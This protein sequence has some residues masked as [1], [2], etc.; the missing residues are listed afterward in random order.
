MVY[1]VAAT[2][3]G[4]LF[5]LES[6]Y[7]DV[8]KKAPADI[9]WVFLTSLDVLPERDNVTVLVRKEPKRSPLHRLWFEHITLP[10]MLKTMAPDLVISL[11]NMPIRRCKLPQLVYLHQ[12]LQ[13][14]Q[15]RFS[16]FKKEERGIAVRQHIICNFYKKALPKAQHIFVQTQW[17]KDATMRWL[18]RPAEDISV[19]PVTVDART[20]PKH[21]YQ[22]QDSRVFFYP[23]RAEMYKNHAVVIDACRRLTAQGIT[24]F[25]VVFTVSEQDGA[26]AARLVAAAQGL[27]IRFVGILPYET[28]WEYYS[29]T[30]LLFPSYL[31]TC[32]IPMLEMRLSGG[33]VIAS[34]TPFTHEA[35]DG[36]PR[37]TF[38]PYADADAL[39]DAMKA[40]LDGDVVPL[41][42][43]ASDDAS[44]T[45]D[46]LM[47]RMLKQVGVL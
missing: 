5:V 18:H 19:V 31:E 25:E 41:P 29:R 37:A 28:V 2:D 43:P 36:Y 11:Q 30:T 23:A 1:D 4:G 34:D 6:F 12:S 22:G 27:P 3:G 33:Y 35:L 7:A 32:G 15:K 26:Y 46:G 16:F 40:R 24:D 20:A 13:Y 17:M 42:A 45:E 10:K 44:E 38:F 39:A 14:C 8:L 47:V 9:Q 21:P